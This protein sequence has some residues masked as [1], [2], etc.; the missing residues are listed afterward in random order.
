MSVSSFKAQ[1]TYWPVV[2]LHSGDPICVCVCVFPMQEIQIGAVSL[3]AIS[4]SFRISRLLNIPQFSVI[5]LSTPFFVFVVPA[6][7]PCW[8]VHF[9]VLNCFFLYVV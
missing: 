1:I 2:M 6:C 9:P 3:P 4:L 8:K 5:N 7:S